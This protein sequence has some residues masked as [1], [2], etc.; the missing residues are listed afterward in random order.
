MKNPSAPCNNPP[1][2]PRK[3]KL[4]T[5]AT[6]ALA[7]ASLC[8]GSSAKAQT[9]TLLATNQNIYVGANFNGIYTNSQLRSALSGTGVTP[10]TLSVSGAPAGVTILFSTNTY[11]S[12]ANPLDTTNSWNP[13]WYSVAVTNVAGRCLS[14]NSTYSL[15]GGATASATVNLIVGPRWVNQVSAGGVGDVNWSTSGNWSTGVAPGAGD[16][17]I[18][19][20]AG[21]TNVVDSSVSIGSLAFLPVIS[22]TNQ[23]M[24]IA[25]GQTLSVLGTNSFAVNNDSSTT[26]SAKTFTLNIFGSGALLGREQQTGV[27]FLPTRR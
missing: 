4:G 24:L 12:A 15:S 14:T 8:F 19:Q 13:I 5:A 23:N 26:P 16:D 17:V 21:N 9:A 20:D 11:A 22:G 6:A 18:F 10:V 7:L 2:R 25:S 27:F 1:P 3:F